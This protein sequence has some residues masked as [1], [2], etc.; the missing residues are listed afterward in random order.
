MKKLT[1]A[2]IG[3]I[4]I[5][6]IGLMITSV[7]AY[8][9][10]AVFTWAPGV[11]NYNPAAN[12]SPGTIDT[13]NLVMG[14]FLGVSPTQPNASGY[15]DSGISVGWDDTFVAGV[16][17]PNTNGDE[18]DGRYAQI[19]DPAEGWWDL[20]FATN[21]V[22]VFLSQDHGPYLGE[23]LETQVYGSNDLWGAVSAQAVLIDVYLDGW[24]PHNVAEDS[25]GNGWCSDD[26]AG[27]YELP[28]VYRYVKIAAWSSVPALNEPEVDAVGA[29][30]PWAE[31][32]KELDALIG[33]VS[34][35]AMPNIIKQRLID[36]LEYAK[37]LKDNAHEEWLAGN[38]DGA[39][40][41]LG[42]AKNQVESFA[43]M[44]EITRRITPE[45]KASF[46]ADATEIIGKIDRLIEHIETTH[47]CI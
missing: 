31:I 20:G 41:K 36:K 33:N 5:I 39:T 30:D 24:R 11:P 8:A 7:F 45:D 3:I 47:S 6:A 46:L 35:A 26:I 10:P 40:K 19:V 15:G 22:V 28:G 44:V 32:N 14:D 25:N 38:F 13:T 43:S 42:V 23:G 1:T 34:N 17:N 16:G 37:E 12:I 18:L 29:V 4:S 9:P 21:R 2:A 27:V